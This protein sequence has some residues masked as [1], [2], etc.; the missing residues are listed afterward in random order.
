M[1]N[2]N[3]RSNIGYLGE[4][5]QF[6]LVHMFIEDKEF[7]KELCDTVNQNMFTQVILRTIVGSM[8]DHYSQHEIVPSYDTLKIILREKANGDSILI[9]QYDETLD[10]ISKIQVESRDYVMELARKFFKQQ[11]II[12]TA[13]KILEIASDGDISKYEACVELLTEAIAKGDKKDDG[14]AVFDDLEEIL[15]DDYR[16][17]IP[18]G[19]SKLDEA[20]EGGIGKGELGVIIA[21]T[22]IGKS[23][24]TTSM[25]QSAAIFKCESNNYQGFKVLQIVFEDSIKAIQRKHIAKICNIE[26]KDLSKDE[27]IDKVREILAN[28]EEREMLQNNLRIVRFPSGELTAAH[29]KRFIKKLTNEGFK[30]DLV[31]VDYFECLMHDTMGSSNEYEAEGRTMRKFESMA[32]ELDI[33]FWIPSQGT[34]DSINLELITVDKMG[35]SVKKSQVAHVIISIAKTI[36]DVSNNKATI[37]LLKNRAGRSGRIFN[38]VDFNNGTCRISTDHVDEFDDLLTFNQNK[39]SELKSVQKELYKSFKY[40]S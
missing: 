8:K 22:G 35:G 13:N 7:F 10:Y 19:I 38:N 28:F 17:P 33:A 3:D 40:G 21:P 11:N 1:I 31:I 37:A 5:F 4:D 29:I 18:T 36:E 16:V 2:N 26:A 27:N 30:P 25:A 39:E 23:S 24:M 12:K 15:S 20:L 6:K 9:E 34:K 32:G 14:K